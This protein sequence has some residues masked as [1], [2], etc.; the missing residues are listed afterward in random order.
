MTKP[1]GR[2]LIVAGSDS[3]GGAGLQADLKTVTVLG[4]FA[5][6]AVTA[7]TAQNTL[8]VHGVVAVDPSF[9]R[10]QMRVVLEDLGADVVKTGML[11]DAAVVAAV[12]AEL[13][14][15]DPRPSVVVDPVMVAKGGAE[16]LDG[17]G[18][19]AILRE[20]VPLA[21]LLTPNAPEA[22]ALT[23]LPVETTAD[24]RRAGEALLEL[25]ARAVYMKGGHVV[26]AEIVDLV[27]ARGEPEVSLRG[28][29]I[30][31]RAT[32]GTGCTLASALAVSLAQGMDLEASA[33]RARAYL[34]RAIERASGLGAG[35]APLDHG[36]PLR[37]APEERP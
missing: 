3:G 25:G 10:R 14:A 26:G 23:G 8:G 9:V 15:S 13:R 35:H 37:V 18:R 1:G 31:S 11:H 7:L 28:P 33:R 4:G 34:V 30:S 17:P 2:V 16:L 21:R 12:A 29:R 5:C 20:L 36:W 22:A 6:T 32:H 24:L 27:L 19:A